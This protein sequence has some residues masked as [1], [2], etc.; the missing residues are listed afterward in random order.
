MNSLATSRF[1][2]LYNALPA[3]VRALSDKTYT[4]WLKDPRHTSLLFKELGGRENKFSVRI[5]DATL[6]CLDETTGHELAR[7][8]CPPRE[9]YGVCS[10]PTVEGD[11]LYFVASSPEVVCLDLKSWLKPDVAAGEADPAQ[12]ILWRYDMAKTFRIKQDH[13][14]SCSV[15]VHGDFVYV[16]TGN[17]RNKHARSAFFPLTPSLIVLNKHTGQLVARDDEQIGEQLWRG[18]WSSPSLATV[19]G[20]E[21]ILFA[22]GNGYCYAFEPVDP[23]AWMANCLSVKASCR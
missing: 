17:E 11:R 7:F 9:V 19:N 13:V 8:H 16:C 12:H 20:K 3:E 4:L 2:K 22:T 10:T 23:A 18:Q 15:L 1:W 21:Q 14:A 5:E 6:L